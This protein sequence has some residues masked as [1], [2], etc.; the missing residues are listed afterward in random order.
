[1]NLLNEEIRVIQHTISH[2]RRGLALESNQSKREKMKKDIKELE[3]LVDEKLEQC[4]D[5]KG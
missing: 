5:Y 4:G 1:M 3:Y 2:M